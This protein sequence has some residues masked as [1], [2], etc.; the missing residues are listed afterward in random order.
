MIRKVAALIAVALATVGSTNA[1]TL[2]TVDLS[3]QNQLT[4]TATDGLSDVTITDSDQV[5]IYLGGIFG[6]TF[7]GP[8][9]FGISGM[10]DLVSNQDV[11]SGGPLLYADPAGGLG[12]NVWNYAVGLE[13]TFIAGE[14][15]F[16]GSATWNLDPSN[17][18]YQA[19]L[20]GTSSGDIFFAAF[21]DAGAL[22]ASVIGQ[23][24]V[25]AAPVP[26]P[27]AL[28]LFLSALAGLRVLRN[29]H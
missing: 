12:L 17:G 28:W 14:T 8:G 22:D 13:S 4:I 23:W 5:G 3:V 11:S 21:T 25:V 15:A 26:V 2:L 20:N 1:A 16:T 6:T 24:E 29:T 18:V 27:A 10:G 7:M 9:L 19:L